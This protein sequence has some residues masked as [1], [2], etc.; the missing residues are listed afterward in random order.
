MQGREVFRGR[1]QKSGRGTERK[2]RAEAAWTACPVSSPGSARVVWSR[3]HPSRLS[4]FCFW[5]LYNP[6]SCCGLSV[7]CGMRYS[8]LGSAVCKGMDAI[9][10]FPGQIV[11][12]CYHLVSL[13]VK[14]KENLP[15]CSSF[16]PVVVTKCPQ[17]GFILAYS[18]LESRWWELKTN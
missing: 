14:K 5:E 3:V 17:K 13:L 10:N 4:S 8:W 11:S 1:A 9:S 16:I 15:N 7:A 6:A 2:D 18:R 12:F